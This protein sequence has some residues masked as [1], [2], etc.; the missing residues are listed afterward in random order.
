M[1]ELLAVFG[2]FCL[3]TVT[4]FLALQGYSRFIYGKYLLH[5]LD[6]NIA[7]LTAKINYLEQTIEDLRAHVKRYEDEQ[8]MLVHRLTNR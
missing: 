3:C 4:G 7:E 5:P 8:T 6:A 1:I 2:T